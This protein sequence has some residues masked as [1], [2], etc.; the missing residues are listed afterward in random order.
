MEDLRKKSL[1]VI[2]LESS[3]RA[4]KEK[5]EEVR[6]ACLLKKSFCSKLVFNVETQN[7]RGCHSELLV[8]FF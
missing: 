3:L 8:Q 5:A 1:E 7:D 6:S 4:A 2:G